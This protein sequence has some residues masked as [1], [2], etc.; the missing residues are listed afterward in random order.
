MKAPLGA[1]GKGPTMMLVEP[2]GSTQAKD[3]YGLST[4]R[5][6]IMPGIPDRSSASW[7]APGRPHPSHFLPWAAVPVLDLGLAEPGR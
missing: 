1:W 3:R 5:S 6:Q 7:A 4:H 2:L